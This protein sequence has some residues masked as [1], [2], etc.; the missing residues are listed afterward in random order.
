MSLR[1]TIRKSL[2]GQ[3]V[4][5]IDNNFNDEKMIIGIIEK[6]EQIGSSYMPVIRFPDNRLVHN[7]GMTIFYSELLLNTLLTL[8]KK[9]RYELFSS[10]LRF[11]FDLM[12][13][14]EQD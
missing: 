1:E 8:T 14:C 10:L 3:K 11:Q 12:I 5:V 13:A 7:F 9:Q 4:I 6:F 2:I